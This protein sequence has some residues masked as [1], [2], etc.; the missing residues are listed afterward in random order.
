MVCFK[1]IWLLAKQSSK[2]FGL[3]NWILMV[4]SQ[5]YG[6]SKATV[7]MIPFVFYEKGLSIAN[8]GFDQI[9]QH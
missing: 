3:K 9:R 4:I 7:N 6:F 8:S 1:N 5:N 2:M